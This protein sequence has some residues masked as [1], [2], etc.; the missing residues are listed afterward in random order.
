MTDSKVKYDDKKATIDTM[1]K[2]D[3]NSKHIHINF[4]RIHSDG[5]A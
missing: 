2:F 3:K 5:T 4:T 1:L